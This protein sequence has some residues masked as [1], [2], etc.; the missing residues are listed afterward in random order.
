MLSNITKIA[1]I[2]MSLNTC[3]LND[4]SY[5][6]L[7]KHAIFLLLHN[8]FFCTVTQFLCD[9]IEE[10]YYTLPLHFQHWTDRAGSHF[11]NQ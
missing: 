10:L 2:Y 8:D 9:F 6:F 5:T 7:V 4:M 11:I 3:V 1:Y